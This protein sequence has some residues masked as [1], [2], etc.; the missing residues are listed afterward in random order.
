[1]SRLEEGTA[2]TWWV[3]GPPRPV[4]HR[5]VP[6]EKD[7]L[8]PNVSSAEVEKSGS[9]LNVLVYLVSLDSGSQT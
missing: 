6:H 4:M 7:C 9:R 1:M 8:A 2:G 5:S 3:E